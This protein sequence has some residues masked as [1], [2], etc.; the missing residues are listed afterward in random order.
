MVHLIWS[1]FQEPLQHHELQSV[2]E[3]E[4]YLG[5]K[6]ILVAPQL[7]LI[8]RFHCIMNHIISYNLY[9]PWLSPLSEP[10]ESKL[11]SESNNQSAI[12]EIRI[13]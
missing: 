9:D 10:Q 1:S 8:V 5:F 3:S 6:C 2:I 7:P 4:M 11:S 12:V 13:K